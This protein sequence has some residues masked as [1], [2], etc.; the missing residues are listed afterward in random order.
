MRVQSYTG[1][2]T[3]SQ[4]FIQRS[5]ESAFCR[6]PRGGHPNPLLTTMWR[7]V[8]HAGRGNLSPLTFGTRCLRSSKH[9][10]RVMHRDQLSLIFALS[11]SLSQNL[12]EQL[13]RLRLDLE[14]R[15]SIS[16]VII[17]RWVFDVGL[18]QL[19][20]MVTSLG[21]HTWLRHLAVALQMKGTNLTS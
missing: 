5:W 16:H 12:V 1:H 10:S 7:P 6:G 13:S 18:R 8:F 14:Q 9:M 21:Y 3:K 19:V 15:R 17:E 20:I 4:Q 2:A 11:L